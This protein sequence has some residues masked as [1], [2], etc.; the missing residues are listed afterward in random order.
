[1]CRAEGSV[2]FK[3]VFF[4]SFSRYFGSDAGSQLFGSEDVDLRTL[5]QGLPAMGK[6]APPAAAA[7][8]TET[9]SSWTKIKAVDPAASKKAPAKLEAVRAKL[10]RATSEAKNA[11]RDIDLRMHTDAYDENSQEA[12]AKLKLI[13]S[14]AQEQVESENMNPEQIKSLM[15][16]VFK[17]KTD[18][19][20][21]KLQKRNSQSH[22]GDGPP[23]AE[24]FSSDSG[25]EHLSHSH[26]VPSKRRRNSPAPRSNAAQPSTSGEKKER[27]VRKSKWSPWEEPQGVAIAPAPMPAAPFIHPSGQPI[28][29]WQQTPLPFNGQANLLPL[30]VL[31]Q[32]PIRP[33]APQVIMAQHGS[34]KTPFGGAERTINIDKVPRE[35]RF[36]DENAIA[37]MRD[38]SG[39]PKEI[40]FQSGERRVTV[41]GKD[42]IVLA[43]N[44]TYKTFLIDDKPHQ[45]RFGSPTRELYIDNEW[46]ECYFGDPPVGIVL[47]G[48]L[49]VF[50]ID[51]PPPQ[52]RIGNLRTDLVLGKVDMYIN[53]DTKI[54]L[55]LDA[56]L[57]VFKMNGQSHS[58][59]FADYFLTVLIDNIPF[60]AQYGAM[61]TKF[62]LP[63]AEYYIRFAVLPSDVVPGKVFVRNMVRTHLQRDLV[64]PP[65]IIVADIVP[66]P[67]TKPLLPAMS[68]VYRFGDQ[69][70]P[71]LPATLNI[72]D[73][74]Q[75]L[76]ETGILPKAAEAVASTSTA[77]KEKVALISLSRPET[78]KR[79]QAG[80]VHTL[81]SG[82]QCSSCG[83]RFPPE[84]TMKYSQHLDWHY[85]QNRRER[86]SAKRAHSRKWHYDV[87]DFIQ[88]VE[89]E[90]L[91]ER[92][93]N[94]F[95]TQQTE[96]ESTNDESNQRSRSP[97]P[98]CLAGPDDH[99]IACD[100]CHD[101]FETFFN[102]ETE[103]WHLRNAIRV[104][105][106]TYHPICYEDYKV[107][108]LWALGSCSRLIAFRISRPQA[109]L[110]LDESTLAATAADTSADDNA[111]DAADIAVKQE[112]QQESAATSHEDDD[113]VIVVPQEEPVITEI[114][115]DDEE[116]PPGDQ[117]SL[118][119][120]ANADEEK[121]NQ[122]D[123]DGSLN[124][125]SDVQIL[126]PQISVMD[127]D[128]FDDPPEVDAATADEASAFPVKIKEEPKYEGYEDDDGFEDVGTYECE[129]IGAM[130][131]EE[132]SGKFGRPLVDRAKHSSNR[133]PFSVDEYIPQS[134]QG[135]PTIITTIDGNVEVQDATPAPIG[136]NKIKINITKN[137]HLNKIPINV[138]ETT[139]SHLAVNNSE[140]VNSSIGGKPDGNG[141]SS[142]NVEEEVDIEYE[143]KDSMKDATFEHQPIVRSGQETSGL[144]SIM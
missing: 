73:L 87:S 110:T 93:K 42:T 92:E 55:F 129:P 63:N 50:K 24:Q 71:T 41:D 100:V 30:P 80:I 112:A 97:P 98:S 106:G 140:K 21:R 34:S 2:Y 113:D 101:K 18:A 70:T 78:I 96:M 62:Q 69:A 51:G 13:M 125:E 72:N 137:V 58:I 67:A 9:N 37:F 32:Q 40:G 86:D 27:R 36:Y 99:D 133:I 43:F 44:D 123:R 83:V 115:D 45:V 26:R 139:D 82:M 76:Q 118:P 10:A 61:P 120:T 47:D 75:K 105:G 25:D 111:T 116:A 131:N 141:N 12:D 54:S 56:Q 109:S 107:S 135:Q 8:A 23:P 3:S 16:Q 85:R 103:E 81:F 38:G 64:S 7:N 39:E 108:A 104:E 59:Q 6:L 68:S 91:E 124:N 28:A 94:W 132:T 144:C 22:K 90:N 84:Q 79:R 136:T 102:E 142:S 31:P 53:M 35:I 65:P 19:E 127:L 138:S 48:K 17:I 143:M 4:L 15:Q 122:E 121:G 1:M 5:T 134:V 57:Q 74:F 119:E 95:E 20:I 33:G 66:P 29:I 114:P 88:Y 14:Q 77:A 117:M 126:E 60:P 11:K 130:T 128:E 89:I 46:Y 49:H 52:V